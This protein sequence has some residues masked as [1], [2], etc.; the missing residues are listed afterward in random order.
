MTPQMEVLSA[1]KDAYYAICWRCR[2]VWW[3]KTKDIADA[4][5]THHPNACLN[6]EQTNEPTRLPHS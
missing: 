1:P 6:K 3:C 4:T 2:G 5:E